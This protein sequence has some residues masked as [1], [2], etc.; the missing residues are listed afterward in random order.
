[1]ELHLR[2]IGCHLPNGIIQS[3]PNL[4]QVNLNLSQSQPVL[5]LPTTSVIVISIFFLI[6]ILI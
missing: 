3:Y 4:T 6:V 2:A 1:M 5:D